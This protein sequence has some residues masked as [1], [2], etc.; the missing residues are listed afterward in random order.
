MLFGHYLYWSKENRTKMLKSLSTLETENIHPQ[1]ANV[2][3]SNIIDKYKNW[4]VDLPSLSLADYAL[5]Y[6]S[7]TYG[8]IAAE[9]DKIESCT[10]PVSNI[11]DTEANPN[12]IV[13]ENKHGEMRKCN[14]P[15]YILFHKVS[16]LK[17]LEEHY[18]RLLQWCL[19]YMP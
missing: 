18:L 15:W 7:K 12:I 10:I 19:I 14:K 5:T 1:D 6:V 2:F 17:N 8:D 13:L 9:P 16:K 11:D 3:A 4:P